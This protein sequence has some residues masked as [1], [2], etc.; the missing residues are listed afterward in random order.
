M[1]KNLY[2][3][4]TCASLAL[5][6]LAETAKV[7]DGKLVDKDGLTLYVFDQDT[8]AGKSA[9]NEGCAATWLPAAV[10]PSDQVSPS[11]SVIKRIDGKQQWAYKGRPLYR[12]V[13][14]RKA[15]DTN[16]DGIAGV[17]HAAKP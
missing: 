1:R 9:C 16:G 3:L 2:L 5:P 15:G 6:A 4:L 11:W 8:A 14:D 10:Q 12:F 7:L 17:W 13:M